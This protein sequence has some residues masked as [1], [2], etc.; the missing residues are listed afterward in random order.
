MNIFSPHYRI[1]VIVFN[2]S[3][4]GYVIHCITSRFDYGVRVY[5]YAITIFVKNTASNN[6]RGKLYGKE[7]N[8]FSVGKRII[9]GITG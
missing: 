7:A 3:Y 5:P 2:L 8:S 6:L 9:T 4:I 1:Q